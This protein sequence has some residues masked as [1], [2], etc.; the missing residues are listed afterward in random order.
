MKT[1][2]TPI[3]DKQKKQYYRFVEDAADKALADVGPDKEGLQRLFER[4]GEFQIYLRVGI[5]RFTT[6][7]LNYETAK[8][9]LGKDFISPE[10]IAKARCVTYT[11]GELAKFGETL[12]PQ[13]VLEWC[14]DNVCMLV[15]GPPSA[16]SL[17]EVRD[18]KN[19]Y[20]YSKK[21]DWYSDE[22]Q[23]FAQSD[24]VEPV[25]FALRKESIAD[26]FKKNW[27]EQSEL[28]GEPM[29]VPN[30]AEV[31]WGLTTYR[32]VLGIY[33]LPNFYVRTS[34][35]DSGGRRVDVGGFDAAGLRVD[36]Y[37]DDGRVSDLGLSG[38]RKF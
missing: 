29:I 9:I 37:W 38:A 4:G 19:E 8:M 34:S 7:A 30:A 12:P 33:L 18:L 6:K 36:C 15:A 3:T 1:L 28:V 31:V 26:S 13:E 21:D 24:K 10:E 5:Y 17:L 27:S 11:E 20:F 2:I 16:M 22:A 32:A 14:R 23:K 25:W 35:L